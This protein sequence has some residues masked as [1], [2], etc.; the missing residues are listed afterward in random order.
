MKDLKSSDDVYL[1]DQVLLELDTYQGAEND[2]KED[3]EKR[4]EAYF[5]G[6]E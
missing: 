6:V 4:L 5:K 3:R 2:N 1:L